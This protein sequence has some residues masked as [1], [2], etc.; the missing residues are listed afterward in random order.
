MLPQKVIFLDESPRDP[1]SFSLP[2]FNEVND[3]ILDNVLGAFLTLCSVANKQLLVTKSYPY[4]VGVK[5][6]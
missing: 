3:K 6:Y 4:D 5:T 1:I 2:R